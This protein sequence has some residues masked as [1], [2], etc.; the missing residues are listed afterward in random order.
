MAWTFNVSQIVRREQ[1]IEVFGTVTFSGN[2][3]TGG[4]NSGTLVIGSN[5]GGWP[6]WRPQ[7]SGL[8]ASLQPISGTFHADAGY[9]GTIVPVAAQVLPKLKLYSAA[10]TE[11]TAGAYPAGVTG[12]TN[13]QLR[14]VYR[15]NL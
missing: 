7:V 8:H 12:A 6:D 14:L 4:D 2:Y 9:T 15:K 1:D 10:D 5:T 3:T 11:V 13:H